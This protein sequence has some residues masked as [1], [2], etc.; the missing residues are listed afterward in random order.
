VCSRGA[1]VSHTTGLTLTHSNR[2][3]GRGWWCWGGRGQGH[4]WPCMATENRSVWMASEARTLRRGGGH[5][6]EEP[7]NPRHLGR[8]VVSPRLGHCTVVGAGKKVCLTIRSLLISSAAKKNTTVRDNRGTHNTHTHHHAC[9]RPRSDCVGSM[10]SL[11]GRRSARAS[12]APAVRPERGRRR[13]HQRQQLA[14]NASG[15]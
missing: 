3:W 9:T 2:M 11:S 7:N 14:R 10:L 12:S 13:V 6:G 5:Q 1:G 4:K 8:R 15:E